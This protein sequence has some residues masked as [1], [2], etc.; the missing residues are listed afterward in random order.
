MPEDNENLTPEQAEVLEDILN[1]RKKIDMNAVKTDIFKIF[2]GRSFQSQNFNE[3][4]FKTFW[5]I[6]GW[7]PNI[8]WKEIIADTIISIGKGIAGVGMAPEGKEKPG[9]KDLGMSYSQWTNMISY[10][11][12]IRYQDLEPAVQ[13]GFDKLYEITPAAQL[14][15]IANAAEKHHNI[16]IEAVLNGQNPPEVVINLEDATVELLSDYSQESDLA[17]KAWLSKDARDDLYKQQ[18]LEIYDKETAETLVNKLSSGEITR[19]EYIREINRLLKA[20]NINPEAFINALQG[21]VVE[22]GSTAGI[23][24]G[25]QNVNANIQDTF[26]QSKALGLTGAEYY[27]L[28]TPLIQEIYGEGEEPLYEYGLGRQLF[29][30][31]SPEEVMELQLLLV[32][33]G[34]LQPFSFVY[35]ILDDN[36][37]GTIQAIES[38][39][40]R[41]NLN[42]EAITTQD[43]YS[44][45]LAPGATAQ[46]LT[47][48]MK[49]SLKD[50]LED[51]AYGSDKFSPTDSSGLNY[52]SLFKYVAPN[53]YSVKATIGSAIEDGLGRPAS[54]YELAA[55]S[56]YINKLSKD[57]QLQNYEINRSN[58][59]ALLEAERRR[60]NYA[61][62]GLDYTPTVELQGTVPQDQIGAVMGQEFDQFVRDKYGP[63]LQGQR[64]SALYN[65]TFTNLLTNLS[66]IGRYIKTR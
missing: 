8:V 60:A 43:L 55:Y 47:V 15:T 17:Y 2:R 59:E 33:A 25:M 41:F 38:A 53:P 66:N 27:G 11:L 34:F 26:L 19:Q 23:D 9:P 40:S 18:A 46:N 54:D 24:M 51:Y 52:Q 4:D 31:A 16:M 20:Q 50:T 1:N 32:E 61:A 62:K 12:G 64:S 29:A 36:D 35:G 48:F 13:D 56:E 3:E 5:E 6:F 45:L 57:I 22:S 58:N 39:M 42:G 10:S 44:I 28:T 63:M 30:N 65:N 49:E 21:Q 37:G 14:R 7:I